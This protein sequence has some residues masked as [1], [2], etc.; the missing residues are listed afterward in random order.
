MPVNSIMNGYLKLYRKIFTSDVWLTSTAS[1]QIVIINLLGMAG[2]SN[3]EITLPYSRKTVCLMPGQFVTT[4]KEI[5]EACNVGGIKRVSEKQIRMALQNLE[6]L[7]FISVEKASTLLKDG[8][9]ITIVKWYYYQSKNA[10]FEGKQKGKEK[11]KQ[12]EAEKPHQQGVFENEDCGEGKEKG[13]QNGKHTYIYKNYKKGIKNNIKQTINSNQVNVESVESVENLNDVLQET[14]NQKPAVKKSI[15]P[16]D[17]VKRCMDYYQK[18]IHPF[19]NTVEKEAVMQ[20]AGEYAE[21]DFMRATDKA[22]ENGV[23]HTRTWKYIAKILDTG[24]VKDF[25]Q[26]N[27]RKNKNDVQATTEEALKILERGD[28]IDL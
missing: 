27:Q 3:T 5:E 13:K 2:W 26:T 1:Q 22:R 10:D 18:V 23:N 20:L 19:C 4:N 15:S 9:I 24:G 25:A 7:N 6:K 28:L 8:K 16:A 11:G 14:Q 12:N 17:S 21:Y